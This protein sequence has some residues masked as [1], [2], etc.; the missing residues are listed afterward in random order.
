MYQNKARLEGLNRDGMQHMSVL[1]CWTGALAGRTRPIRAR[2]T[3]PVTVAVAVTVNCW[4][5]SLSSSSPPPTGGVRPTDPRTPSLCPSSPS[6]AR[7]RNTLN[8]SLW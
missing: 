2:P 7:T 5:V 8:P 1:C 3:G 6:A 4:H